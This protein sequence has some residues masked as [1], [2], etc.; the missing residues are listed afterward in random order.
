[1]SLM[2]RV[3]RL[4]FGASSGTGRDIDRKLVSDVTDAI[5]EAVDPRVKLR[6]GFRDKLAEGVRLTIAHLRAL[7]RESL[8]PLVLS[9][10]AWSQDP[11]VR[12]FFASADDIPACIGR[13]R[14]IRRFFEQHAACDEAWAL[15]GMRRDE[16][17]VLAPRLVGGVMRPDVAQTTV[18]FTGHRLIAPA[19]DE[20]GARLEIGMRIMQRLAQLVGARIV[21]VDEKVKDLELHK[22]YLAMKLR[23]LQH[24]RD[25]LGALVTDPA[26]VELQIADVERE[27]AEATR[28]H[29]E[30][31]ASLATLDGTIAHINA[32]LTHPDQQ[33]DLV[34][35]RMRVTLLG[36]QVEGSATDEPANDLL[37]DDLSIGE[38][39]TVT[40]ALVRIPRTE[41]PPKEGLL[42]R[43]EQLL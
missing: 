15:L 17:R 7:A 39:L 25:G 34:H 38:G 36:V 6:S 24:G 23:M 22:A 21:A 43:A 8:Q 10:A 26:T 40:I 5:V 4:L 32:I 20:P 18:S 29:R 14:E 37:L 16:K 1:M 12:A 41:L 13:S 42:A 35:R 33:V 19:A 11:H 31:K 9:R 30:A 27:L 3:T 28:G 2:D